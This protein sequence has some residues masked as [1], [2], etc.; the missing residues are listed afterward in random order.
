MILI[1]PMSNNFVVISNEIRIIK[2][3]NIKKAQALICPH[4][5]IKQKR[6]NQANY[7]KVSND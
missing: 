1:N 7:S 5:S 4:L 3:E 6:Q 2:M